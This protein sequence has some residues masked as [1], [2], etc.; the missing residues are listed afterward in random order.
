LK[1][2]EAAINA[3]EKDLIRGRARWMAELNEFFRDYRVM[4]TAFDLYA[5]GRTR[6]KGLFLSRFF[7]STV[8]PDYSVSLFCVGEDGTGLSSDEIRRKAE[9]VT[10]IIDKMALKW[11]WLIILTERRLLPSVVSFTQGYEKRELGLAVGSLQ[12]GQA[13]FS[14]NQLGRSIRY[15]IGLNKLLGKL[16]N[17]QVN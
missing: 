15:R 4:D 8:L 10:R 11:A 2:T 13:V 12:S 14:N 3:L 5:R 17:E 9:T 1:P 6:S 16:K 7:A